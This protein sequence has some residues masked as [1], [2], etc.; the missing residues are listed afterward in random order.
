MQTVTSPHYGTN[1][2]QVKFGSNEHCFRPSRLACAGRHTTASWRS[3]M[4]WTTVGP[5]AS[6]R[7]SASSCEATVHKTV[8]RQNSTLALRGDLIFFAYP[9]TTFGTSIRARKAGELDGLFTWAESKCADDLSGVWRTALEQ[10]RDDNPDAYAAGYLAGLRKVEAARR[11]IGV[12]DTCERFVKPHY[13][14]GNRPL[15]NA[16]WAPE[17]PDPT[18]KQVSATERSVAHDW[19]A[20]IVPMGSGPSKPVTPTAQPISEDPQFGTDGRCLDW[21]HANKNGYFDECKRREDAARPRAIRP[22]APSGAKVGELMDELEALGD[23]V[24]EQVAPQIPVG[25]SETA[26]AIEAEGLLRQLADEREA[27]R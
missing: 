7:G 2:E 21:S 3:T 13:A 5:S 14:L 17:F 24:E 27:K 10:Y 26:R 25:V 22:S 1:R 16:L 18:G 9:A 6:W 19:W 20:R 23:P 12:W 4:I 8:P 15:W 11:A